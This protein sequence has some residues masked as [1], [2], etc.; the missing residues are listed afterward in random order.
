MLSKNEPVILY[1]HSIDNEFHRSVKNN[2]FEEQILYLINNGYKFLNFTEYCKRINTYKGK[3]VSITFDDGYEDNYINA[4]PILKKYD[5]PATIFISTAYIGNNTN[6][7]ND[8]SYLYEDRNMLTKKQIIEMSRNNIEIGSHSHHHIN[9]NNT[10]DEDIIK[11]EINTSITIL[12]DII[13]KDI[14]CFSYPNGQRGAFS[15][16]TEK[17][18]KD[19]GIRYASTTL[20]YKLP[21]E[22]SNSMTMPRIEINRKDSFDT[23]KD[24]IKGKYMFMAVYYRFINGSK[25]WEHHENIN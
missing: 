25:Q 8:I 6:T 7:T 11:K 1:Y 19:C 22:K 2:D 15:K 5:I 3:Y 12:K 18:I 20:F 13:G 23:F 4:F 17:I 9:L 10:V 21:Y 16:K 24:K 14:I